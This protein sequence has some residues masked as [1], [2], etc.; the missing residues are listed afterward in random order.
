MNFLHIWCESLFYE[1]KVEK[2]LTILICNLWQ[3][4]IRLEARHFT[5]SLLVKKEYV[6]LWFNKSLA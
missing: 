1:S 4:G 5:Q 6:R 2:S 3:S